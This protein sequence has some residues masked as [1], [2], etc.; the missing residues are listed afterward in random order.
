MKHNPTSNLCKSQSCV[1][2]KLILGQSVSYARGQTLFKADPNIPLLSARV[3]SCFPLKHKTAQP[4]HPERRAGTQ[5]G[6]ELCSA[7]GSIPG[8]WLQWSHL[9]VAGH[10][11]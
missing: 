3:C 11:P 5:A 4:A 2:N 9:G 8:K 1:C 10:H 7:R 6:A